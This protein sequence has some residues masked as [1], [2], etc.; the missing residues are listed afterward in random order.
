M[1]CEK[2]EMV[3]LTPVCFR[4]CGVKLRISMDSHHY[5]VFFSGVRLTEGAVSH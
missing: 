1:W 5:F 4:G 3:N 2:L